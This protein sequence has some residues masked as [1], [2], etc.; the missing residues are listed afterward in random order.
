MSGFGTIPVFLML[1]F[2]LSVQIVYGVAAWFRQ[3]LES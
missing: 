2:F 1:L 3:E